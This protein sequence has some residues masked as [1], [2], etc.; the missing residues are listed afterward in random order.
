MKNRVENLE[1]EVTQQRERAH[2]IISE[3][4]TQLSE[5]RKLMENLR[6]S[7]EGGRKGFRKK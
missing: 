7:D 5:Q 2:S 1:K 4:T 3:L 6:Q